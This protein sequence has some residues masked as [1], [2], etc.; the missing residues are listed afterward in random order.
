MKLRP[1]IGLVLLVGF[2][3]FLLRSF[4]GQI[5]A[6]MDFDQARDSNDKVVHVVGQWVAEE[7]LEYNP[8]NNILSFQMRDEIGNVR[9]VHYMNPKPA[10]FEEAEKLVIEGSAQGEIFVADKI[11]TKCPSKYNEGAA[12][13][14]G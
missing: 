4:G 3:F 14:V 11:L 13:P 6:Y 1:I 8:E 2:T 12:P 7:G 10:N 9:E 5:G